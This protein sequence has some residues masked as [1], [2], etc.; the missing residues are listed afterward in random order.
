[1]I[2]SHRVGT[3]EP[4][5]LL[6][7]I[8]HRWQAWQPV[9]D[10]LAEHHDVL[11]V[12]LPGF[13]ASA[14]PDGPVGMRDTVARLHAFV[15]GLGVE[16]PHVAGNSLGGAI[17][18]ELAAAGLAASVTA[19]SPAGFATP[20]E[21]RW[22]LGTLRMHRFTARVPD[23]VLHRVAR[24]P[25]LRMLAFGM[26]VA[27]PGLLDPDVAVADARALR[28]CPGFPPVARAARGYRFTGDPEVPVTVAWGVK[29]RILFPRQANRARRGLPGARHLAL[30]GCGH[31]PM[32]D[33]PD[34]VARIILET[35]GALPRQAAPV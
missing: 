16:R 31:V 8:G 1:M 11:A 21:V 25:R 30:P 20:W 35:T 15:T 12:D 4:L 10:R 33:A 18:L 2:A 14:L 29:D 9:L 13:G 28:D 5:L 27:R 17:A 23:P 34:L 19:L 6:H 3:G 22:A 24:S 26:I 7:G 32:S